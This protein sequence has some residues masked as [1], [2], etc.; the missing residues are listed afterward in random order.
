[1][2]RNTITEPW[3]PVT[4]VRWQQEMRRAILTDCLS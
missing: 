2:H 1:L 3:L 4:P